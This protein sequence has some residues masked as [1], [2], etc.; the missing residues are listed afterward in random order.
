MESER[1]GSVAH[2]GQA[3]VCAVTRLASASAL[4]SVC[5][6]AVPALCSAVR[7]GCDSSRGHRVRQGAEDA[8][9]LLSLSRGVLSR[10]TAERARFSTRAGDP[11]SS[12]RRRRATIDPRGV[13][14]LCS[15]LA[16]RQRTA[17]C[18]AQHSRTA[19]Q[20]HLASAPLS[21]SPPLPHH[22]SSLAHTDSP[23]S[24]LPLL[25]R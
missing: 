17:D 18:T 6:R 3:S 4:A 11:R 13:R 8:A 1:S 5:T 24:L 2:E 7:C 22:S 14:A 12:Q 9:V 16:E 23:L 15:A 25:P 19:P 10:A 21:A 20:R